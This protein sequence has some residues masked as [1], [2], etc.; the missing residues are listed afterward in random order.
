MIDRHLVEALLLGHVTVDDDGRQ[1]GRIQMIEHRFGIKRGND[2]DAR[3]A[4]GD[5]SLDA[6][7]FPDLVVTAQCMDEFVVRGDRPFI[8]RVGERGQI[9]KG[10]VRHT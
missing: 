4:I 10:R 3:D 5:Q 9:G 2:D 8:E 7:Q 6:R 1:L